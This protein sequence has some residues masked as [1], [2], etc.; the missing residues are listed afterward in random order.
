MPKSRKR[1]TKKKPVNASP[2]SCPYFDYPV[3]D[4]PV[5]ATKPCRE[6]LERYMR[7]Y[8]SA[9]IDTPILAMLALWSKHHGRLPDDRQ[10]IYAPLMGKDVHVQIQ[11][12]EHSISCW[13]DG[14]DNPVLEATS[15]DGSS[16]LIC[17]QRDLDEAV[18]EMHSTMH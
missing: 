18:S 1:K 4:Y 5:F 12:I 6:L 16:T 14:D 11:H 8:P 13:L 9:P 17:M 7:Q 15:L 2:A 3:F 10:H